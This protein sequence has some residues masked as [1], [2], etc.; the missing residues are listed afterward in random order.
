M[1]SGTTKFRLFWLA[2]FSTAVGSLLS[3]V[4]RRGAVINLPHPSRLT[5]IAR[6]RLARY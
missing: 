6:S 3:G 4:W 2:K 1:E 5:L